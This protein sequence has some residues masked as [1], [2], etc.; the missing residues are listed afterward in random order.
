MRKKRKGGT[1]ILFIAR[2]FR[3]NN[4]KK[5]RWLAREKNI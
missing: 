4:K 5:V 3:N 2:F 1:K